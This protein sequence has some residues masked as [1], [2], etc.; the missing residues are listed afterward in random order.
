MEWTGTKHSSMRDT[1]V[2][3]SAWYRHIDTKALTH[4]VSNGEYG[5]TLNPK[6]HYGYIGKTMFGTSDRVH[7]TLCK[8]DFT[9]SNASLIKFN[10]FAMKT[11]MTI[12]KTCVATQGDDS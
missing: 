10:T 5:E 4:T 7:C 2:S 8:G 6:T 12:C 11:H 1:L 9:V 3:V